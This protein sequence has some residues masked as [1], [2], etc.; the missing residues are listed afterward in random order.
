MTKKPREERTIKGEIEG[1]SREITPFPGGRG[2]RGMKVEG[3]WHNVIG[4]KDFL[5]LA[6]KT[7]APGSFIVFA[8]KKNKKGYW[9]V[10]EGTLKKIT[11]EETYSKDIQDEIPQETNRGKKLVERGEPGFD[12][13]EEK[14]REITQD[15]INL[16]KTEIRKMETNISQKEH[17]IIKLTHNKKNI[18][19]SLRYA[20][21][22]EKNQILSAEGMIVDYEYDLD[23]EVTVNALASKIEEAKAEI[24]RHEKNIKARELEIEG[25]NAKSRDEKARVELKRKHQ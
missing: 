8:E 18:Q 24:S 13:P 22:Q 21:Q 2:S 23:N 14:V 5:E 7:F 16:F 11:K 4:S 10:I 12:V 25:A 1:Y 9:D 20:I 3:E 6:E 19:Q 17:E 15:D